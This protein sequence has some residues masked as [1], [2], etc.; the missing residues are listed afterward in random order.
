[1]SEAW[2][3]YLDPDEKVIWEG[4]P[5]RQLFLFRSSDAVLIPFAAFW[6]LIA[7]VIGAQGLA[8][9]SLF[10]AVFQLIFPI[11]GLYLLIGRFFWEAYKRRRTV[12]ALTNKR[13]FNASR[14][15]GRSMRDMAL[16]PS[17]E[18]SWKGNA[19]GSLTFEPKA[20]L[21]SHAGSWGVW[22]G[23]DGS[24]TF[25]GVPAPENLYLKARDVVRGT[26]A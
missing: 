17:V 26:A 22:T 10:H 5:S 13:A 4:A 21:F 23:D 19:K 7:L 15:L 1:V 9:G 12:Y 6:A 25:R 14:A 2:A 20:Y 24:L 8:S 16:T 18:M 3:K 11:V